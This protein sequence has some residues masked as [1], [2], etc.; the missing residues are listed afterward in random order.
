MEQIFNIIHNPSLESLLGFLITFGITVLYSQSR[1]ILNRI[2]L[3]EFKHVATMFAL[4]R[5]LG[6]GFL[7]DYHNKLDELKEDNKFKTKGE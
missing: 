4:G 5:A 2:R 1:R 7:D 3:S 6:N